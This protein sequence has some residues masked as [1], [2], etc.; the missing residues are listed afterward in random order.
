MSIDTLLLAAVGAATP[1]PSP[2]G[3]EVPPADVTSPGLIGFLVMF[4]LA[5]VC[6]VLFLSLTK[7]L[8]LV[9][10]R[11]ARIDREAGPEN[12]DG[13]EDTDGAGTQ[14][15]APRDAGPDRPAAGPLPDD[16]RH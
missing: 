8:R 7:Q 10:H 15:T 13:D 4:G 2:T 9:S 11:A 12:G 1:S 5:L 14:G 6:V 3:V 16:E